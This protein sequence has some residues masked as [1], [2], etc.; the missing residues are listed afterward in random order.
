MQN[1]KATDIERMNMFIYG[2]AAEMADRLNFI[3]EFL[4]TFKKINRS[5]QSIFEYIILAS[6]VILM[7]LGFTQ[8]PFFAS[9]RDSFENAFNRAVIKILE[10]PVYTYTYS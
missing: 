7:L 5:G 8:T 2:R 9:I 1:D 10:V 6:L 3:V 4:T